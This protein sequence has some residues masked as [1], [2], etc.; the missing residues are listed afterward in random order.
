MNMYSNDFDV[1]ISAANVRISRASYHASREQSAS[2]HSRSA[3]RS[4]YLHNDDDWGCGA[5]VYIVALLTQ[6][7]TIGVADKLHR[8]A[9]DNVI[10]T[11][12]RRMKLDEHSPRSSTK[13][14]QLFASAQAE[15]FLTHTAA[16]DP[17]IPPPTEKRW[18]YD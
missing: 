17:R 5:V 1:S 3:Y 12:D 14:V 7:L 15:L 8:L 18:L 11:W 16:L 9:V 6:L 2:L 4:I 13:F 10:A